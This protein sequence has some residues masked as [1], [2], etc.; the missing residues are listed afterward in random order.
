MRQFE[1]L[2]MGTRVGFAFLVSNSIAVF[3]Q[4]E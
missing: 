4:I 2:E 3:F 1:N